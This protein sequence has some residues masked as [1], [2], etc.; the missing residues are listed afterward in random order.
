MVDPLRW[1]LT[2]LRRLA[3]ALKGEGYE[4]SP[5]TVAVLL[6]ERKYRL[7]GNRKTLEW[8]SIGSVERW[9]T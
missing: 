6:R 1:T 7:Q 3:E 8:T 9:R 5:D 4:V 2:S